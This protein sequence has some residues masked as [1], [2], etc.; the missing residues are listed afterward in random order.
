MV[1]VAV[2]AT[3]AA[4]VVGWLAG[5]VTLKRSAHWCQGCGA[6]LGC[7]ECRERRRRVDAGLGSEMSNGD[8]PVNDAVSR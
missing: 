1:A 7:V 5:M 2:I 6:R 4:L 8:V 3:T